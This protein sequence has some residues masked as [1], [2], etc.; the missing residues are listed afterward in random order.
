MRYVRYIERR[1]MMSYR[2]E[3][4]KTKSSPYVLIDEEKGYIRLEG[5]CYRED[6]P[7]FF[8]ELNQWLDRYLSSDF[9]MLTFDCALSYF[10][11]SS[12]KQIFN[13]L[14]L[15]DKKASGK[16][17]VV[18]WIVANPNNTVLIECGEDFK[19]DVTNIEFNLNIQGRD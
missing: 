1:C 3:I 8:L 16:K 14:R 2:L 11:S 17:V 6:I 12:T 5:E 4:E 18:N 7:I 9:A 13:M 19:S 15:M 10:N